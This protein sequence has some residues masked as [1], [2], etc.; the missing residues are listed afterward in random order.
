MLFRSIPIK[1]FK[2]ILNIENINFYKLSKGSSEQSEKIK[3]Y[4]NLFDL[5]ERSFHEIS[6]YMAKLDLVISSDTSI[7][8]LAG[9]LNIRSILLLNYN[10]DW[11][12]FDDN[13]STI[14]YPSIKILKQKKF[15]DWTN[16]FSELEDFL[17]NFL[18][19][20]KKG[21]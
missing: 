16:V 17:K 4:P 18:L 20:K 12:W 19:D 13:K 7:I 9:I 21:Q 2:N 15:D 5:G 10:S 8:H 6:N 11:R 14:W 1:N 3:S